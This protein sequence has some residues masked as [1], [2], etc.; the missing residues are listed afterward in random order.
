MLF[1]LLYCALSRTQYIIQ[2]DLALRERVLVSRL[3]VDVRIS[4]LMS[5]PHC[6]NSGRAAQ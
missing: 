2:F 6:S 3:E 4:P 1:Q 5:Q